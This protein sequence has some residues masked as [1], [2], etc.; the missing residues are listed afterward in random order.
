VKFAVAS[1]ALRP[2][3]LVPSVRELAR[4]LTVNPNTVA[5]AYREL[6][7]DNVLQALR[8]TGLEITSS[9]PKKCLADRASLI[10]G[11]LRSV[12]AEA[13]Q[14]GLAADEIRSLTEEELARLEPQRDPS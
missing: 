3:N 2:G 4:D 1:D 13:R 10:R 11:R 8:G 6:Q 7:A 14:S 12:L 9:A 5:R